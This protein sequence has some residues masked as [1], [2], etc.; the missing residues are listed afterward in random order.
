[1]LHWP[2]KDHDEKLDY[3]LDWTSRLGDDII[4]ASAWTIEG[5]DTDL[6]AAVSPAPS[7]A[8]KATT[9][10][11][12]GGTNRLTYLVTNRVTTAGG[13]IMDQSAKLRIMSK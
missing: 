2:D 12:T 8:D 9:V 3:S 6:V 13:R 4:V 5:V 1:M 10:W 11:M 7:F